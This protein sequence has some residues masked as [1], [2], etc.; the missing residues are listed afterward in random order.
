MIF[1]TAPHL[2][3]PDTLRFIRALI[4]QV[5]QASFRVFGKGRGPKQALDKGVSESGPSGEFEIASVSS[6][7]AL[8]S[9]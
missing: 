9:A 5:Q 3:H 1:S 2:A 7:K 6:H 4:D 8:L